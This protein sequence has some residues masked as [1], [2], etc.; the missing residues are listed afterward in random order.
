VSNGIWDKAGPL[1]ASEME[2]VRFHPYLTERM[3]AFTPRLAEL[4][5]IAVQHHERLDGS[6]YPRGLSGSSI[7]LPGRVLAAADSYAT[8]L[9]PR[10]HRPA[11]EREEAGAALR[12]AVDAGKLDGEAVEAVLQAAGHRTRRR[13]HLPEGLTAREVEVLRLLALGLTN[14]A[15]AEK[16]TISRKTAG[17]HIEHIYAK[18]GA[19]NRATAGLFAMQHG[20]M[21]DLER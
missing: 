1:T 9:E 12:A 2:R 4:G 8:K 7:S 15:I 5:A 20:L 21:S 3:L 16:L 18:T 13:R 14:R 11:L 19:N 10:P 6:G 17:A